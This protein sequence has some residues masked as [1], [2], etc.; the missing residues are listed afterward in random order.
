MNNSTQNP[1]NALQPVDLDSP[2]DKQVASLASAVVGNDG[3]SMKAVFE[4]V[5][6]QRG[7]DLRAMIS[8]IDE[9]YIS[10]KL[11]EQERDELYEQ[12]RAG[13][14]MKNSVDLYKAF[15]TLEER[16]RKL[17]EAKTE[18]RSVE[19]YA[20]GKWYRRGEKCLFDGQV[21]TCTA[22]EGVVCTWSPR[23]YPP[24]WISET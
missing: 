19:P 6:K 18:E 13:A 16:V 2:M 21:Y 24:Y 15:L 5:I 11:T 12:A 7:Y 23:E 14:D 3:G 8:R 17:E 9:F 4:K 10:G 1:M 20:A 22:P